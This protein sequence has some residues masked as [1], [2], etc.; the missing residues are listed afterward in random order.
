[1]ISFFFNKI[2]NITARKRAFPKI[3][4]FSETLSD[5]CITWQSDHGYSVFHRVS[6]CHWIS[7]NSSL[8]KLRL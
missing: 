4:G 3:P 2:F 8:R 7:N 6:V 5:G 1:M